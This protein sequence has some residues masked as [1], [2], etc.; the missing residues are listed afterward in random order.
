MARVCCLDIAPT[1]RAWT[2]QGWIFTTPAKND[3]K[4]SYL[5]LILRKAAGTVWFDDLK[6]EEIGK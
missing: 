3:R 1:R 4:L 5:R 6:L 2:R